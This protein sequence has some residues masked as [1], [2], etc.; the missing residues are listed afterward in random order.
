MQPKQRSSD[1]DELFRS[2]LDQILNRQHSLFEL[3]DSIDWSVFEKEFGSL[4]R[5][6]ITQVY[7]LLLRDGLK[8]IQITHAV[9]QS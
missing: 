3:A 1:Q 6:L 8:L 4:P 5:R 7:R 9:C 2:R